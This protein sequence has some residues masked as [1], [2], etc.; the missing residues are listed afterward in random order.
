MTERFNRRKSIEATVVC[1][2]Y[3]SKQI[4]A[5]CAALLVLQ[6]RPDTESTLA[7]W[8]PELPAWAASVRVRHLIHHTSGPP[9]VALDTDQDRT[10][11][12]ANALIEDLTAGRRL[13]WWSPMDAPM[14]P[15]WRRDINMISGPSA[16]PPVPKPP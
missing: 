13:C 9:D 7:R 15:H 10:A 8:M 4:T 1:T 16:I 14:S 5:A 6:G 12:L 3:L 2:A 11:R